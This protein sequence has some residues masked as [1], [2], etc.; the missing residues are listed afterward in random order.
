M[1]VS[2]FLEDIYPKFKIFKKQKTDL[3][4][5]PAPLL[6][7]N[8][9]ISNSSGFPQIRIS[10]NDSGVLANVKVSWF[11]V[12]W[13]HPLGPENH[14]NSGFL[15]F[16]KSNRKVTSSKWSRIS[17]RSFWAIIFIIKMAAL[18]RPQNQVLSRIFQIFDGKPGLKLS[19]SACT[20]NQS[21]H[22]YSHTTNRRRRKGN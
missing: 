2:C 6:K 5:Y 18:P 21:S 20:H 11:G 10:T 9:A 13:S 7:N 22:I 19:V 15:V 14:K 12:S 4:D 16:P 8:K 17:L 3:R 1:S